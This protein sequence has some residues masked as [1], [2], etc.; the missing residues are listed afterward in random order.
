MR[1]DR[2][3]QARPDS[4]VRVAADARHDRGG[5][6]GR[7]GASRAGVHRGQARLGSAGAGSR[8]RRSPRRRRPRG[9]GR[10]R[11]DPDRRRARLRRRRDHCDPRRARARAARRLLAR[12]AVRAG[13]VRGLRRA[14]GRGR[15]HDRG[16]RAGRDPLG[17][18]RA[19][20]TRTRRP[21]P[22]RRHPVR[23]DHRDDADR[24]AGGG[25]RRRARSARLEE[26][27]HQGRLVA[28][29]R[30]A[31]RGALP[32]VLRRGDRDQHE[33]DS[34]A[35]PKS[36]RT[37]ASPSRPRPDSES[38]STRTS[39]RP[40]AWRH[41]D[42]D[43]IR[44]RRAARC[45]SRRRHSRRGEQRPAARPRAR[46]PRRHR[47]ERFD[48]HRRGRPRL[49]RLPLRLRP[50]AARPQ[51]PRRRRGRR[52][53]VQPDGSRRHPGRDRARRAARRRRA[54]A[55]EGAADRDRERGDLPRAPA[56]AHGHR[57]PARDQVP[58][59]LPRLAR[60]GRDE[61]DL[62]CR[63]GRR[64]GP[65]LAGDPPRGPR[66]DDRLP[67]STTRRTSSAR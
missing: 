53:R 28:R 57:P 1:A 50:A 18:P 14:R 49:H 12:G 4:R 13:R 38:I 52:Q 5:H 29:E 66:R 47:D 55:R 20:R 25:A 26:W 15:P 67:R 19:D 56:R 39:S 21:D 51:R 37:A 46:G 45:S 36:R 43:L 7:L 3:G 27:D 59:L 11:R 60:R 24:G 16:G 61:R 32:G 30:R 10:R 63:A 31:A 8:P 2:H 40:Y 41:D 6:R 34:P 9:R 65:A 22:A 42:S 44:H 58:G 48:V 17:L 64:Q 23:R 33:A 54:L 62:A 35:A